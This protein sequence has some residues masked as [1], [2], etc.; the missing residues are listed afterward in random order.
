MKRPAQLIA[1]T[2]ICAALSGLSGLLAPPAAFASQPRAAAAHVR[3]HARRVGKVRHSACHASARTRSHSRRAACR[4]S[5]RKLRTAVRTH[6]QPSAPAPSPERTVTESSIV[7]RPTDGTLRN[8][9]A[10]A[11]ALAE[12]CPNTELAPEQG[13]VDLLRAAVLCLIN[14]ER[15]AHDENPLRLNGELEG[16]A[17]GHCAE[18]VAEDYFAHVSPS[19]ETPVDRIRATGYIP[20]PSVG[21]VIGENLAWGTY[22]LAT[23]QAIVAAWIASPGHLANILEAKYTETGIGITPAVPAS[24]ARRRTR[25]DLRA[26]VRRYRSLE[27]ARRRIAREILAPVIS[28]RYSG[29]TRE[30]RWSKR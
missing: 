17:E 14:R 5:A 11:A 30:R 24:L 29:L 26:G 28:F 6:T 22:A 15:A 4:A 10:I 7:A 27:L 20:G 18:L 9:V 21:Y 12:P 3:S 23:P 16:A 19:G 25:R 8:A 1:T 13:N 2:V